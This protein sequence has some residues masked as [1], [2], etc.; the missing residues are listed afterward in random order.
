MRKLFLAIALLAA[1]LLPV[2]ARAQTEIVLQNVNVQLWPEYDQPAV[3]A[4]MD[5][6]LVT[7][8]TFPVQVTLRIP[9]QATLTAVAKDENGLV[10][11]PSE[12]ADAIGDWRTVSLSVADAGTYRLEYYYP[13]AQSGNT[14]SFSFQWP[15][16]YAVKNLQ[17]QLQE[18]TEV[19]NLSTNPAMSDAFPSS[20]G[21]LLHEVG[22][23]DLVAGDSYSL[24]IQYDRTTDEMSASKLTVEPSGGNIAPSQQS[25]SLT[26]VLP[27]ALGALGLLLI[28]GG[29][30]WYWQSGRGTTVKL[31]RRNRHPVTHKDKDDDDEPEAIYCHQCGKR[32]SAGDKFCRACGTRL[33]LEE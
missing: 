8:S 4:I 16:G 31:R 29:G 5:F 22:A 24:D 10:T 12:T 25:L 9:A 15:G 18:P 23:T 26:T 27:Y 11:V 21:M 32:A 17:I 1:L 7:D 19:K 13:F 33:R 20:N 6:S 30:V 28:I 14:R 3:L 2:S